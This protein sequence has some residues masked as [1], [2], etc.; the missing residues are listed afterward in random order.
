[1]TAFQ[2]N[3]SAQ[4]GGATAPQPTPDALANALGRTAGQAPQGGTGRTRPRAHSAGARPPPGSQPLVG[5]RPTAAHPAG[6]RTPPA[7]QPP[8]RAPEQ[9]GGVPQG[10]SGNPFVASEA[11]IARAQAAAQQGG[12]RKPRGPLQDIVPGNHGKPGGAVGHKV[13]ADHIAE[14]SYFS[15]SS[16]TG[17][18][19]ADLESSFRKAPSFVTDLG[20]SI[21]PTATTS[22]VDPVREAELS[23]ESWSH[24]ATTVEDLFLEVL[25]TRY[26]YIK[27]HHDY[28]RSIAAQP[29]YGWVVARLYD[30]LVR[31][32]AFADETYDLSTPNMILL[33]DVCNQHY[34]NIAVGAARAA[35]AAHAHSAT[36]SP[37]K[38]TAG[39]DF[40]EG[41]PK[42]KK[43]NTGSIAGSPTS[44]FRCGRAGHLP[45]TC[46]ATTTIAGK[47]V[48]NI[49]S[50]PRASPHALVG[51]N[52]DDYCFAFAK[53]VVTPIDANAV[54]QVLT[55]LGLLDKW[56]HV[57][58]SLRSGFDTG[59]D[60]IVS[61]TI[62]ARNHAS[63]LTHSS[64]IDAHIAAEQA[65]G[66]Y[67]RGFSPQELE[68]VLGGPFRT[69]PLGAV[70]KPNSHKIRVVQDYSWSP[71]SDTPSVNEPIDVDQFPTQ[72]DDFD[73]V[74]G[75]ILSLPPGAEAA[76]FDITAAYRITPIRPDQQHVLC[77]FWR[78][79]VYLDF[80]ASFG[81]SSSCGIFG[82]IADMLVD[83][84]KASGFTH[85]VK[86]VDDFFAVRLPGESWTEDD[87]M[88]LTRTLGVPWSIDKLKRFAVIQRFIGF[89]WHLSDKTVALPEEKLEALLALIRS[90]QEPDARFSQHDSESLHGKLVHA[91][92]IFRLI[93]PF[94]RSISL[95]ASRFRSR[96]ARLRVP[97]PL[98]A[99]LGWVLE[100]VAVSPVCRPLALPDVSDIQ[101]W[102]DASTS[103]GIGVS[104]G[105]FW[106]AW[107]Y[108]PGVIVGPKKA[109]DIG[110]AEALA[111]ELGLRMA[112]HHGIL[113]RLPANASRIRVL[114]DN[115][116][117]VTVLTKGRSR[118]ANTN[119][120]LKRIYLH[121]ARRGLS[122][123]PDWVSGRTHPLFDA[124][125]PAPRHLRNAVV[126]PVRAFVIRPPELFEEQGT[127]VPVRLELRPSPLRPPVPSGDRIFL[128]KGVHAPPR[129]TI[130]HPV[131]QHLA[132]IASRHSLRDRQAYGSA[133]RKYHLFCDH[134]SI[135]EADRLP[136]SF[137]L[138]NSFVLWCAAD[139]DP[140]DR[141]LADGVTIFEPVSP[142][143]VSKYLS[144][145]RAWHLA[146]GWPPPLADVDQALIRWHLRGLAIM[147]AGK[148]KRP[149]RPPVTIRMLAALRESLDLSDPF[150]ACVWAAACCAFW[151]M[152]R[153]G[154]VSVK[155][156]TDFAPS[157]H[158]TRGDV[159]LST[160]TFG[161]TVV[162][163]HLPSAKTAAPGEVQTVHI[164]DQ[165]GPLSVVAALANLSRVVPA[166]ANDPLFC[167]R[168]RSGAI[169]PLVRKPALDCINR[170]TEALGWGTSFGHSFRI[171][172]ASFYLSKGV[173]PE[174]V[175]LAGRW[176][177]LAYEAYIRAFQEIASAHMGGLAPA[178]SA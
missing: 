132:R 105:G 50:R 64:A 63:A 129:S 65:A 53:G 154:E 121:L 57:V 140:A 119:E 9:S 157:R 43:A 98:L 5:A 37:L 42:R 169:R 62:L 91:S 75:L 174:I 44:C 148:R 88:E 175:R 27:S 156:R 25:P 149:P 134:F 103:F 176:K 79:L 6:N 159:E 69:S 59:V 118:S 13:V 136:A 55:R 8:T 168:D 73:I 92:C 23:Y 97:G 56:K 86:W 145:I 71:N 10:A 12:P 117:V 163:L 35:V 29:Q 66:R 126:M 60:T 133:L 31:R 155:S 74:S 93:R 24:A 96:H 112:D 22:I 45:G 41:G 120:V 99:D 2:T 4:A 108:A 18:G 84:Y 19:A 102:G 109:Y 111:V 104:V 47:P 128:W 162:M 125:T 26:S 17:S 151:G 107:S 164:V 110:W 34:R 161:N 124:H 14:W 78:D 52:G 81:L 67:S 131:I 1:M 177:S 150:Q 3:P 32:K 28:V 40:D 68:D 170:I 142:D 20:F 171:G 94:L 72:F 141:V 80:A 113:D 7:P 178:A 11:D 139:P 15:Y 33:G 46:T 122:L 135:P 146:Q 138:L 143:T 83:I 160:D 39:A 106:D 61:A 85:V 95:F 172:G 101:W 165:P 48:A 144:G 114:S 137:A 38:R 167:W 158:L 173:N 58:S 21:T 166:A 130:D 127:V 36:S 153:F 90:W 51:P 16:V 123:V 115:T 76:A 87:F 82:A 77:I 100:I 147:Q 49:S 116:G 152:M 89:V 70:P 30:I 54:E